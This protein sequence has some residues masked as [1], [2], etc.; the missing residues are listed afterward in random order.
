MLA[1]RSQS[2]PFAALAALL[3]SLFLFAGPLVSAAR[4]VRTC[5]TGQPS[6]QG[7]KD[8]EAFCCPAGLEC[9]ASQA[10]FA[11]CDTPKGGVQAQAA[12]PHF[13]CCVGGTY[14]VEMNPG[15]PTCPGGG[16]GRDPAASE[17]EE[18]SLRPFPGLHPAP[19]IGTTR[20]PT[21]YDKR[22]FGS[23]GDD[24]YDTSNDLLPTRPLPG[25]LDRLRPYAARPSAVSKLSELRLSPDWD[26]YA[27]PQRREYFWEIAEH[28]GS[29]DGV[30]RPLLLINGQFPGPLVEVNNGDLV[31]VHVK[32]SLAS[33]TTVHFHGITQN[34]SN[35]ADGPSGVTQCP[36]PPGVTFTYQFSPSDEHQYGT[37]WHHSHRRA[38]YIDGISGPVIVHSPRDPL[39]R[40]RDFD[41]EQI[42]FLQDWYHDMSD[43]IVDALLSPQG[44]N[45]TFIAP[46]PKSGLINGAGIYDC[47]QAS[48]DRACDQKTQ[49]DLPEL[50][51]P[52]NK[53]IRLRFIY[54]GAHP[55]MFVSV[56]EH[57]LSVIEADDCPVWPVPVHRI[58]INLA[59]RYSAVLDTSKDAVGDTFYLRTHINTECLDAPFP[60]LI[61]QTR[62][63]IR[64]GE[65]G[66]DLGTELPRSRDWND[67]ST[68]P[69]T[70]L[71]ER[72]L[73]PRVLEPTPEKPDMIRYYNSSRIGPLNVTDQAGLN[74]GVDEL[75]WTV[76]NITFENMANDPLLHRIVRGENPQT[77]TISAIET[78]GLGTVDL[79]IQNL[80][81]PPHPFHLHGR[82]FAIVARG[83]GVI[84]PEEVAALEVNTYNP[85]RR[86]TLSLLRNSWV[87]IRII[88]D[89]PGA[90]AWHCHILWH[91]AQGLLG[92]LVVQPEIMRT[93]K[94]PQENYD[95]CRV[96]SPY[97]VDVGAKKRA[98]LLPPSPSQ[99]PAADPLP[100]R[101]RRARIGLA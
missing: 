53:R 48:R 58:P 43:T 55:E 66:Q 3:L 30:H 28:P 46:S 60:D 44:S 14:C 70:D 101:R 86:D 33:G 34:H 41:L 84:S 72:L 37:Y 11:S 26:V 62:L 23:D 12:G 90:W 92:A 71:D 40:G 29:P 81:G 100:D 76:N 25:G 20:L 79:V 13:P 19:R 50:V 7:W 94:I 24:I 65:E 51:F 1:L 21:S 96:G 2:G 59:Q 80:L 42:I 57:V 22:A 49:R 83:E 64:V 77:N 56:D 4:Q 78:H 38:T 93:F 73:R 89:T 52:P 27:P 45:H 39:K 16:E 31:V 61:T 68:G 88:T 63:V 74:E 10:G 6:C 35:W 15:W 85:L 69:C 87:I 75:L 36:I 18:D 91:Q 95:L 8:T 67:P 99:D 9:Q 47:S 17:E 98:L 32:N 54:A 82:P 5:P 97:A